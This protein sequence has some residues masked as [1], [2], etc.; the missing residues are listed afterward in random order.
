MIIIGIDP[1]TA[2]TGYGII[3]IKNPRSPAGSG[4]G[5]RQKAKSKNRLRCLDYGV[6]QTDPSL[7]PEERLKKLHNTLS[8]LLRE[9]QPKVLATEKLYFFKNLKTAIPVSQAQGVILL[10]AAKKKIEV[11]QLT[12]L[13]VKMGICGYGRAEKT[14]IQRMIKGILDLKEIPRPDDAADALAIAVCCAIKTRKGA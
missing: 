13:E 1:G 6:I 10:A 11:Q 5:D 8:K 14:Q 3:K 2:T 7:S 9:Y 12:P 4:I